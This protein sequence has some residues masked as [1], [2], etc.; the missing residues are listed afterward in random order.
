MWSVF[1]III[2]YFENCR[3]DIAKSTVHYSVTN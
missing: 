1:I 3:S 2:V